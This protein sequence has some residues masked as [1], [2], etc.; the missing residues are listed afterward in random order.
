MLGLSAA[1]PA[2]AQE[3]PRELL[4]PHAQ[5]KRIE[6]AHRA[7]YVQLTPASLPQ[8]LAF[9]LA[10]TE[11]SWRLDFPGDLE[12]QAWVAA[13]EKTQE[14]PNFMLGLSHRVSKVN[15]NLT[16]GAVPSTSPYRGQTIITM[17]VSPRT[18]GQGG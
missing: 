13:L 12:M 1:G 6:S 16:L 8:V 18:F 3:P 2:L 4:Y 10:H 17:Y 11:R 5:I 14:M 15:V 9:Y 7:V